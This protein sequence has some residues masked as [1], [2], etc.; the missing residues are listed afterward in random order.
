[1][2]LPWKNV[3]LIVREYCRRKTRL[4]KISRSIRC[5]SMHFL[6][7]DCRRR[8]ARKSWK[9]I[10]QRTKQPTWRRRRFGHLHS[11]TP[12]IPWWVTTRTKTTSS[13]R[14]NSRAITITIT[15]WTL[16]TWKTICIRNR[17]FTSHRAQKAFSL[18][19][20]RTRT[21]CSITSMLK[22]WDR[23]FHFSCLSRCNRTRCTINTISNSRRRS[24]IVPDREKLLFRSV[25]DALCFEF[26]IFKKLHASLCETFWEKKFASAKY[27]FI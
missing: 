6:G 10:T 15:T 11:Q 20:F 1:M 23:K 7:S 8:M 16:I 13:S 24:I 17:T 25:R 3:S 18:W 2:A 19:I 5:S 9:V 21:I 4:K 12:F 22:S 27:Q 14:F 26:I